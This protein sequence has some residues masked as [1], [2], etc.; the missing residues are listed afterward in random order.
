MSMQV[1]QGMSNLYLAYL[2]SDKPMLP[3]SLPMWYLQAHTLVT[4]I[5]FNILPATGAP[6]NYGGSLRLSVKA[7]DSNQYYMI[8]K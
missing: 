3:L 7:K 5:I 1:K 8:T 6:Q 4:H 2:E